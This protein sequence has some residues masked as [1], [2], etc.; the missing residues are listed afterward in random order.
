M[1]GSIVATPGKPL[2]DAQIPLPSLVLRLR[3]TWSVPTV[4]TEPS[5]MPSHSAS[6]SERLRIGGLTLASTPAGD[7]SS[8]SR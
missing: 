8:S 2:L 4:F 5:A 6:T 7:A 1:I 3:G